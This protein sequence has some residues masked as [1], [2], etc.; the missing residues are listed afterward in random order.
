M[1]KTRFLHFR[2]KRNLNKSSQYTKKQPRLATA[3]YATLT[4]VAQRYIC[5]HGHHLDLEF[6]AETHGWGNQFG[7]QVK[8]RLLE[9]ATQNKWPPQMTEN[10]YL[11]VGHCHTQ[12]Y[13][14]ER[15]VISSGTWHDV[16]RVGEGLM[17]YVIVENKGQEDIIQ[18]LQWDAL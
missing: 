8:D 2:V 11:I 5:L 14:R 3:D 7:V 10:D 18:L 17:G 13:N 16:K 12:F 1:F 4:T 15:Q 6:L 9:W